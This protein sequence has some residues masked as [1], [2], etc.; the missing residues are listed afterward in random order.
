MS[1]NE[2]EIDD[3]KYKLWHIIDDLDD[4]DFEDHSEE[5]DKI[6]KI[7]NITSPLFYN[8]WNDFLPDIKTKDIKECLININKIIINEK[9]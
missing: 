1:I 9:K 5:Y 3:I 7:E 6:N 4:L 8:N 2:D